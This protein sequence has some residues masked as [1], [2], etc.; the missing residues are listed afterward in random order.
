MSRSL[1]FAGILAGI[2][3]G[4]FVGIVMLGAACGD[5]E[6]SAGGCEGLCNKLC[7]LA[8]DCIKSTSQSDCYF[9]STSA[10]GATQVQGRNPA[11]RGCELGMIRDVCGDTT[12]PATLFAACEAALGEAKCEVDGS[13]D[14]LALPAACQGLLDCK[15]G[16]CLD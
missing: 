3:V 6:S 12:K 13:D 7:R 9:K 2:L 8:T 1:W 16:P 5:G 15:S 14:V 10:E 4:I 11:G